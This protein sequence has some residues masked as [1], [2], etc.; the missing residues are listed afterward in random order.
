M[1]GRGLSYVIETVRRVWNMEPHRDVRIPP[2]INSDSEPIPV[3]ALWTDYALRPSAT[4]LAF[5][6]QSVSQSNIERWKQRLGRYP[7]RA[8]LL[9]YCANGFT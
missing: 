1:T 9:L 2:V 6:V 3:D 8:G 5:M 4:N 7:I